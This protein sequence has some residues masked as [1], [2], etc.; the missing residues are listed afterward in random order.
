[1]ERE[2]GVRSLRAMFEELLLEVRFTLSQ[3]KGERLVVTREF[4]LERLVRR[5]RDDDQQTP[6][7]KTA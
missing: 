3:R 5:R 1:M 7:Q 4:V 6:Q 2:T